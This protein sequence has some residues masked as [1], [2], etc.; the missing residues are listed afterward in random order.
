VEVADLNGDNVP[1]IMAA[2]Y[3]NTSYG[4]QSYVYALDGTSGDTLW[5]P[6]MAEDGLRSMAV[7]DLNNDGVTDI[8]V[9][10]SYNTSGTPDGRVHAIDGA[11]GH[12]LWT[13][14]IGVTISAVTV[15]DFN[16]DAFLDVAAGDFDGFVYAINGE[17]GGLLWSEEFGSMWI[18]ALAAADING[19]N[20]D[21][22]AYAH[23][24]LAGWDNYYG[25]L[26]GETGDH[27]WGDTV[28]YLNMAVAVADIDNDAELEAIWGVIYA[29][30]HGEVHVRTASDGT[31]EWS[32]NLG[33]MNHTNGNVVLGIADLEDDGEPDLV[34]GSFLGDHLVYL[35]DGDSNTPLW[36]SDTLDGN[37]RDFAFGDVND[38]KDV[39]VI[40]AA[41]AQVEVLSGFDGSYLF[42]YAVAGIMYSVACAD[43]D[44]DEIMEIAAGGGANHTGDDPGIGVWLLRTIIS[45]LL[46]EHPFGEYGNGIAV[47]D[48]NADGFEDVVT[49]S[50]LDDFARGINGET[51]EQLWT[52]QGT[53]NLYA[54][55]TGDFNGDDTT[56]AAVGGADQIVTAIYGQNGS[57]IWQYTAPAD[58]IYRKCI[59]AADLDDDGADEVVAGAEDNYVYAIKTATKRQFWATDVGGEVTDVEIAQMN[60]AGPPDVVVGV[61]GGPDGEKVIVL[62]GSD[63]S[64]LWH[65]NAGN[66]VEHVGAGDFDED[67]IMDAVIAVTPYA[68]RHIEVISGADQSMIRYRVVEVA[69]NVNGIA[70]GDL[71][72]D[73]VP[74]ILVP[75]TSTD[76]HVRAIDG[77][78]S[79][80][81][82]AFATGGEVNCVMVAD[83]D[84]DGYN[85]AVAGSDDQNIYVIDG[86][87]GE[88]D[89]NYGCA[90][91]VMDVDMGDIS[92]DGLP[93]LVCLTFGSNGVAY[94]FKSLATGPQYVCGDVTG[95]EV[96]NILDISFMIA[97]LYLG[98]PAPDPLLSG[99]ANGDGILNILDISYLIEFV[100]LGGP[101]PI[102]EG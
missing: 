56:D 63:G 14:Y 45:P 57:A 37:T 62:N 22:I 94:A 20:I 86:I 85:E 19:D 49:V 30:D 25:F 13:Y 41:S 100:Y 8:I 95:D 93:N 24:Y 74:D 91:D 11:T 10:A 16:G 5:A 54:V 9:G 78:N 66:S 70:V 90:D 40:C 32:Y 87:T 39:D 36:I 6:Y 26:D 101:D 82:W 75:G 67:G 79:Q 72:D 71:N 48:F 12:D 55:A 88:A 43:F 31:F 64:E 65:Y 102:C 18:N 99:D 52:W 38:D 58:Q 35:F 7:G 2:E 28:E 3:S 98:G 51:G 27:I 68:P 76:K 21:D 23:E 33:S 29:D 1:D 46:W 50:S 73:K 17:T 4:A 77:T 59:E 44:N 80:E 15:G 81:L 47:G 96:V 61:G 92:G 60:N 53:A 84:L 34:V 83:V 69:S 89:F 42:Q 97:Y